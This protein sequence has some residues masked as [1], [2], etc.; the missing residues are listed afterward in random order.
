MRREDALDVEP[1]AQLQD[2]DEAAAEH[3]DIHAVYAG[4]AQA[5][6]DLGPHAAMMFPVRRDGGRV[7]AKVHGQHVSAHTSPA[8]YYTLPVKSKHLHAFRR[9]AVLG[10]PPEAADQDRI[11]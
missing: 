3:V 5:V 4:A 6:D 9:R 7:V 2:H 11:S 10:S 1:V 8:E